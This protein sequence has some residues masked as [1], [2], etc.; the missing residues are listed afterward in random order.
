[1]NGPAIEDF[2]PLPDQWVVGGLDTSLSTKPPGQ[3]TIQTS[4][5]DE[6]PINLRHQAELEASGI[7]ASVARDRGYR[8]ANTKAELSRLGFKRSQQNDPGIIMPIHGVADHITGYQYKPDNPRTINGKVVKYETP[9]KSATQLDIPRSVQVLVRKVEFSL[10]FT[11]GIKKGDAAATRELAVAALAGVWNW[12]SED[13]LAEL[14]QIPLKERTVY[15]AFDSDWRRKREV[16]Q[17][18]RR[19]GKVLEHRGAVVYVISL[20]EPSPGT[21]VG[22]DDYFVAG[23]TARDLTV[24][25]AMPLAEF[26]GFA[27][28]DERSVLVAA[29]VPDAPVHNGAIVPTGYTLSDSEVRRGS[30]RILPAAVIITAR[31]IDAATGEESVELAFRD[32]GVWRSITTNRDVIAIARKI[33]ELARSGLPVT[34]NTARD[35]V[36]WL[37]DYIVVN[38]DSLPV[39]RT[40]KRLGWQG[41]SG[42]LLPARYITENDATSPIRFSPVDDGTAQFAAAFAATGTLDGWKDVVRPLAHLERVRF[43]VHASFAAAVLQILP[44]PSFVIDY[45][46]PTSGGKTSVLRVAGSVWGQPDPAQPSSVISTFQST[47]IYKERVVGML[48]GLPIFIDDA[49]QAKASEVETFIY[50]LCNGQGRGRGSL[51]GLQPTA[52]GRS[53]AQITGESPATA[54]TEAGG[55]KARTLTLWGSPFGHSENAAHLISAV[56]HGISGHHG[57][58]GPAFVDWLLLNRD[59]WPAWRLAYQKLVQEC[60]SR[61]GGSHVNS[62]ICAYVA[63]VDFAAQL[64]ARAGVVPWDFA[65]ISDGLLLEVA[66]E[67]R[68]ADV[69]ADALLLVLSWAAGRADS[70]YRLNGSSQQPPSG[71]LGRWDGVDGNW[72][73]IAFTSDRLRDALRANGF[74]DFEGIVR[75][76]AD[77]GWLDLGNG[78]GQARRMKKVRIASNPCW[79]YVIVK[80]AEESAR[81]ALEGGS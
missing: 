57:Q 49:K 55:T 47:R 64:A 63:A 73:L 26:D 70:F 52:N 19:L 17:A 59:Q 5:W 65:R 35:V 72:S 15:I 48:V 77:R 33:S 54:A 21:K 23:G 58:A 24:K 36:D 29:V 71:W 76:W 20:P 51:Q 12:R 69:S 18:L 62:R 41:T 81:S 42:F 43:A 74:L 31:M 25:Y 22:L 37:A 68:T 45:C 16:R 34:S 10:F 32:R 38:A 28:D 30:K 2:Q 14:D 53:V 61:V 1:M 44:C 4:P 78:D 50:D 39:I 9:A 6:L 46:G 80:N 8:T 40:S 75:Q 13:V 11:E 3:Q 27:E 60:T 79:C 7:S 67:A 56:M 66:G